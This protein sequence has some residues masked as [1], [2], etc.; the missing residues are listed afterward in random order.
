MNELFS[1]GQRWVSHADSS[2]G[3]GIVTQVDERRVTLH[4]P[5][6]EEERVYATDRAPLTRLLLKSGDRLAREDGQYFTV[7]SVTHRDGLAIYDTRDEDGREQTVYEAELDAHIELN[8]PTE[9]LLNNQL[10]RAG[11]FDLRRITLEHSAAGE[12]FG[13]QGL[14]GPRTSLLSHQLYV[15]A[16]I[17]KRSAPR[18]LLADE[19]GLG[20]T[21]E[22]GLILSQQLLRQRV[23]RVLILTPESLTHQWLVEMQRRFHLS[24]SLLNEHRL[25]DADPEEEFS[26]NPLVIS[27]INLFSKQIELQRT[28]AEL[29]WDMVIVDEAHHITG[30]SDPQSDLGVFVAQLAERTRGLL[31]LTA[32]PE[33]AGQE[34]HFERLRLIDPSRF[35]NFDQFLQEQSQFAHWNQII[36]RIEAGSQP[37]LPEGIDGSGTP[38]AQIQQMLDRYGT[39]RVLYRNSR[40]A[41]GGFPER[42]LHSYPMTPP[43]LYANG[44][45]SLQPE[46]A[47]EEAQWI[48]EDP[49][50]T[51]LQDVLKDLRPEKVLV[52]C[53]KKETALALEH[54]LH[55]KAGVRCAA[56]HEALSLV[57]RDRAA[58]YFAEELSGAQALIC[59]EIGSEGRNF[60]FARHLVCFDLPAHPDLL[61]QRIGRLD[62]IGQGAEIHIHVPYFIGT[63]QESLF[64][65]LHEGLNAF[66]ATCSFGHQIYSEFESTLQSVMQDNHS[67][68]TL[69]QATSQR[70]EKLALETERGRDRLLERHSHDKDIGSQI[71]NSLEQRESASALYDFTEL[72]FDRMG[73]DQDYLEEKL[74]LIRPTENLVTGQLPGL[75]EDGTTVTYDRATALAREDVVFLTWEHP[76]IIESMAALLG[77]DIGKA[78]LGTFSHKGVPAGTF[79][80]EA[81]FRVECLAPRYLQAG[82][83]LDYTPMRMLVTKDGKEVGD[84]LSSAFLTGALQS[85]PTATSAAVLSKLRASL[86][87]LVDALDR[88]AVDALTERRDAALKSA[89]IFYEDELSRLAYLSTI[90]PGVTQRD[91]EVIS[92]EQQACL[93]ALQQ[94][95][96]MLEGLRV[97]IAV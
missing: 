13:L 58:A 17:G 41:V 22:A 81:V 36:E 95:R 97:C 9:R 48:E 75:S 21:I 82:Q 40:R 23:T 93:S 88:R 19:V 2:L 73:I 89:S 14:L 32:T 53:A 26:D 65:W 7:L 78:C 11:D 12:G 20:K 71:I 84:K 16:S 44:S 59:S 92:A 10:S 94:T 51:W 45:L 80:L 54:H 4:F 50:V 30:L 64:L 49:R 52:I 5:A 77:S 85:V 47:F 69:I 76:I 29:Q 86:E 24:F 63:A 8:T 38:E 67:L 6:V 34:S 79:L 91:L 62:R 55:L 33:Q 42:H 25:E 39:G 46:L 15:A 90:N 57:E 35:P 96:P 43:P 18:V 87:S 27:P 60:Q 68:D 72:L 66:C 83:F 61:E 31:L 3:L 28:V 37:E 1:P 70:R 74:S 56:F